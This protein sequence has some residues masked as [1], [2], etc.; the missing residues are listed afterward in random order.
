MCGRTTAWSAVDSRFEALCWLTALLITCAPAA[1]ADGGI[2]L[3]D[4]TR[5][6]VSE[7]TQGAHSSVYLS[8]VCADTPTKLRLCEPGEQ[9]SILTTFP[10]FDE[11]TPYEWNAVPLSLYLYGSTARHCRSLRRNTDSSKSWNVRLS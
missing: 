9:G 11:Q 4:P 2:A 6:G 1:R 10:D 8:G 7:W 5:G 3:A